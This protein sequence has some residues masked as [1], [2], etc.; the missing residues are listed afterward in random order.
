MAFEQLISTE[1]RNHRTIEFRVLFVGGLS[2]RKGARYLFQAFRVSPCKKGTGHR[3]LGGRRGEAAGRRIG[4]L[5]VK[6]IGVI[7]NTKLKYLYSASHAFVL[8]SIEEG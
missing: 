8:P 5:D 1:S 3:R 2:I 6:F 4:D 7:A